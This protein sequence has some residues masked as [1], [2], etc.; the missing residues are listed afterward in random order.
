MFT[1]GL[2]SIYFIQFKFFFSPFFLL[3]SPSLFVCLSGPFRSD[4][5]V[6]YSRLLSLFHS[7]LLIFC[8]FIIIMIIRKHNSTEK[9]HRRH[10][11]SHLKALLV[12]ALPIREFQHFQAVIGALSSGFIIWHEI[13]GPALGG[14]SGWSD[15][16]HP[17]SKSRL[18]SKF[19][20]FFSPCSCQKSFAFAN[21]SLL[22][23]ELR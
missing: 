23:C 13:G 16:G 11:A 10:C 7:F 6:C 4:P 2:W 1:Q 22:H 20:V 17:C 8:L 3:V 14:T 18:N 9:C 21:V 19:G 15:F 12:H 5:L